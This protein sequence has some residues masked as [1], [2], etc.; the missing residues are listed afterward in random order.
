MNKNI[1]YT[2]EQ[3]PIDSI[4]V[5]LDRT[6]DKRGHDL[7]TESI[8]KY[9]LLI[10]ITVVKRSDGKYKLVKG[11]GRLLAHQKLGLDKI[12]TFVFN[13]EDFPDNEIIENWLIEN[14]IRD[15]LSNLDKAR[16]MKMEFEKNKSYE[17]TAEIFL[18]TP[19]TVKQYIN[20]LDK[21]SEKVIKMVED[22]K[23][24][25]TQAKELSMTVKS[26]EAQESVAD[27]IVRNKLS[28]PAS[29]LI[30]KTA[31]EIEQKNQKVTIQLLEK[32]LSALRA[33]IK[34]LKILLGALQQRYNRLIPHVKAL[35]K[36][37]EFVAFLKK[38]DLTIPEITEEVSYAY[39]Y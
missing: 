6:R 26:K 7:L 30:L 29:R 8:R 16:L 5:F 35:M 33:E 18:T 27:L 32:N 36:D 12:K 37:S 3:I 23:I 20:M 1:K 11:Q 9:G 17:E 21:I 22:N 4:E 19:F 39:K 14:E 38:Y 2:V 28:Q 25:F 10:P 34:D 13:E 15:K 24:S 31:K